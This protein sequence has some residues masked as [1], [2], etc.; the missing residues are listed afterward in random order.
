[1]IIYKSEKQLVNSLKKIK[2][3]CLSKK[4]IL[5]TDIFNLGFYR[6][7]LSYEKNLKFIHD[8]ILDI[9]FDFEIIVPTFNYEF[10]KSKLYDVK[11][12]K[13]EVGVLNEYF[14]K[15][16]IKT[17]TFTPVFNVVTTNNNSLIQKKPSFDP[18]GESSFFKIAYDQHFDIIFLGKFI[19]SMAH[20]VER[21]M[22]VPYRY[23]KIFKGKIKYL[24][25][26]IKSTTNKYNVRPPFSNLV[27]KDIK[28]IIID[29]KKNNILFSIE[30]KIV[31]LDVTIQEQ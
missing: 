28:K 23:Y 3:N 20:F 22:N 10:L 24:N 19:P 14:R 2:L 8:L 30:K 25:G 31:L 6:E 5:H 27:K 26:K 16:Y 12:D 21:K 15:K 29:L 18:H 11:K 7:N 4:L 9:F 1:M 17:R 13:S